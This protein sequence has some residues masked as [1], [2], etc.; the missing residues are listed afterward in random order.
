MRLILSELRVFPRS[1][2]DVRS[3]VVMASVTV[4]FFLILR[5]SL[6]KAPEWKFIFSKINFLKVNSSTQFKIII[7]SV[8]I[9]ISQQL[10]PLVLLDTI[11]HSVLVSLPS[12]DSKLTF[13]VGFYYYLIAF[14]PSA[15]K[16]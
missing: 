5:I 8:R 2:R 13:L 11:Q 15:D 16:M 3:L 10:L 7:K 6:R 12:T 14:F 9:K 4:L 1:F